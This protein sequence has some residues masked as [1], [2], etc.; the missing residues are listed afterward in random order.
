MESK[1]EAKQ[2]RIHNKVRDGIQVCADRE[3][4]SLILRNLLTNAIKYTKPGG[5]VCVDAEEQDEMVVV[6]VR[7]NGIGIGPERMRLLFGGVPLGSSPG[8]EGCVEPE[9]VC[10]CAR[11]LC[12]EA[13]EKL[14]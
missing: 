13:V 8:T 12:K 6:T 2:V 14:G 7:D 11:S 3:A 4:V 10:S 1:S 9:S 5:L